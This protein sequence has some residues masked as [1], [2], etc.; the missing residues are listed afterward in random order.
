M[1]FYVFISCVKHIEFTQNKNKTAIIRAAYYL[2]ILIW[3]GL[4]GKMETAGNL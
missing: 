1:S 4:S 2:H 3:I